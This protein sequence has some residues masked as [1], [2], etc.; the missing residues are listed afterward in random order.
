MIHQIAPVPQKTTRLGLG[1]KDLIQAHD[2][3]ARVR[4]R[5]HGKAQPESG[6]VSSPLTGLPYMVP[7]LRWIE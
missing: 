2:I 7:I 6:L 3:Q 4:N 1:W 5:A